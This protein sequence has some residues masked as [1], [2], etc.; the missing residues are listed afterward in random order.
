MTTVQDHK[1]V[2][3]I[4]VDKRLV[5]WMLSSSNRSPFFDICKEGLTTTPDSELWNTESLETLADLPQPTRILC[6]ILCQSRFQ[7]YM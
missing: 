2:C 7:H 6:E 1:H 4:Q 5:S 3:A